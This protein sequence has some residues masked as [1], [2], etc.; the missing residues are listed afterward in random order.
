MTALSR[1]FRSLSPNRIGS[2]VIALACA[3]ALLYVGRVLLITL[4]VALILAFMLE[5]FVSLLIRL[6]LPRALASFVVCGFA[7]CAVYLVG[8]GVYTQAAGF[9]DNIPK[10]SERISGTVDQIVERVD[11]IERQVYDLVVPKRFREQPQ[12]PPPENQT[13]RR[14]AVELP[15]PPVLPPAPALAPEVRI[16][17]ERPVL[18]DF[19]YAHL[20]PLYDTLLMASFVPFLVYFMLSWQDHVYRRFLEIFDGDG[21]TMAAKT[22]QGIANMVRAFV[23]GNFVLGLLLAVA[24]AVVFRWFSLPYPFLIGPMSGF[25]SLVP[26]IGLPL[27]LIPPFAGLLIA[28]S[29]LASYGAILGI[30]ALLHLVALNLLYPKI[31]GPRVHLN[32]LVVTVALMFWSALWGVAGLVLAI[33][34]TAGI[35]AVCDNVSRLAPVGNFLGD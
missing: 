3:I 33:P 27:A 15:P 20:G 31:V 16:Q 35:K 10:Y 28:D 13:R 6:R 2:F 19:A 18:L 4:S 21:R 26:Y 1:S 12:Q 7:I 11:K 30:V 22:V 23:V 17:P 25:L 34:L 32:P 5:P 14:R 24:G 9:V 8:L 29:P